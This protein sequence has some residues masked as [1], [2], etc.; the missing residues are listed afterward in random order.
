MWRVA[1]V[2]LSPITL[3]PTHL[4]F[5]PSNYHG[6]LSQHNE[7][8]NTQEKFEG[9]TA[10]NVVVFCLLSS[11]S[12]GIPPRPS[13]PPAAFPIAGFLGSLCHHWIY[14]PNLT[15]VLP[16]RGHPSNEVTP[17][18]ITALLY[19]GHPVLPQKAPTPP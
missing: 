11:R 15:C 13:P 18:L 4:C 14:P 5:T 10:V 2:D 19:P 16:T 6:I 8:W 12:L 17:A 3:T 9:G 7:M 1:G